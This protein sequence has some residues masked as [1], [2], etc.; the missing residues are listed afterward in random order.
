MQAEDSRVRS[1]RIIPRLDVKGDRLVKGVHLEGIRPLGKPEEFARRYYEDGAD[2]L[3]YMDVVASLYGRNSML[4]IVEGTACYVFV[5]ITV[6]GGIR[7]VDDIRGALRAG[8]DKV[9]VNTWAV[10]HPEFITQAANTFGSSAVVVSI[11]AK[12][13]GTGWEAYTDCGRERS[14]LDAVAWAKRAVELGAGELLVTSIDRDGT[15]RGYDAELVAL[16][17]PHVS[18]PVVACGGAGSADHVATVVHE[19]KADAVCVGAALHYGKM[20]IAGLKAELTG[21]GLKV[22]RA[23]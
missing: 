14:G 16:I 3:L 23:A 11:E 1:L 4:D 17:A 5:P 9:A 13:R 22:R 12:R 20:T 2:E 18:V 15:M 6:G 10:Q 8:A 21:K 19:G 7:S